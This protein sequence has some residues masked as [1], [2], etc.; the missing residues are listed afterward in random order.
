M[1]GANTTIDARAA[2]RGVIRKRYGV[3]VVGPMWSTLSP[4]ARPPK[5]LRSLDADDWQITLAKASEIMS[6]QGYTMADTDLEEAETART[7]AAVGAS[8]VLLV[9]KTSGAQFAAKAKR[10]RSFAF[11]MGVTTATGITVALLS[12]HLVR[13]AKGER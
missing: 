8:V 5:G 3:D 1:S 4:A 13:K 9:T 10:R 6:G 7:E 12:A 11:A 2:L